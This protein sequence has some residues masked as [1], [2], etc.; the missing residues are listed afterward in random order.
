[1][2]RDIWERKADPKNAV[3]A[4]LLKTWLEMSPEERR[5]VLEEA[6]IE[7]EAAAARWCR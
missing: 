4:G 3:F 6:R 2:E 1:M 5:R 7:G